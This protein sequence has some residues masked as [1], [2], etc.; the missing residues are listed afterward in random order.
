M[1]TTGAVFPHAGA[2]L[3]QC[4]SLDWLTENGWIAYNGLQQLAYFITVFVAAPVALITGLGMSPALSTRFKRV[5]KVL[6]IQA[7][8]SLH[9]L[10]LKGIEFVADFA[11]IG[12]G[13]GGYNQGHEF[14]GY[15][16][17]I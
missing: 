7:A 9:F 1:P 15:R 10:V 2:V 8:R 12:G 5:S 16:Q 14:F 4:L 3:I 13:Y 11:D 6:S 17:S